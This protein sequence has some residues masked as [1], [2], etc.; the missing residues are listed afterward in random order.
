MKKIN[1]KTLSIVILILFI[2]T[3]KVYGM[4]DGSILDLTTD[5]NDYSISIKI[6]LL[7]TLLTLTPA[8]LMTMT[9]FTRIIIVLH[10]VRSSVGTQQT[11]PNQV[12]I[13]LALFLTLFIMTPI[14]SEINT[15]AIQPYLN[16]E[17]NQDEVIEKGLEPIRNFMFKQT[18]SK[19]L[20]LFLDI[21]EINETEN[22]KIEDIPTK[23]LIPS[24]IIGEIK[25]AFK[26]GFIIYIP[27][28]VIDMVVAST[29]MSMGM[30]MLPP[31][32][33]SLPFKL[34]LFVMVDGWDLVIK[35]LVLGFN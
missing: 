27:F 32:M 21:A 4:P 25:K 1:K 31:V 5:N 23:V 22:M 7:F 19:D 30:M 29:L 9:S 13:G 34:L 3:S 16:D 15:E 18:E 2:F 35:S 17:I 26:M 8:I 24:F 28:L 14:A 10:F 20:A 11:P 6:M 12:L 33:I